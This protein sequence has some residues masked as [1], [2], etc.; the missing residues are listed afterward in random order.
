MKLQLAWHADLG[1]Q[2]YEVVE[3][4]VAT[5]LHDK[6]TRIVNPSSMYF[7]VE[8]HVAYD[9]ADA[10]TFEAPPRAPESITSLVLAAYGVS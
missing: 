2:V 8:H 1:G 7:R 6:A 9:E 10:S 4:A 3:E 5:I